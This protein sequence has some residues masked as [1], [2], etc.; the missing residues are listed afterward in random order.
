MACG[1][2]EYLELSRIENPKVQLTAL[3][4]NDK[5]GAQ[6]E[7][8]TRNNSRGRQFIKHPCGNFRCPISGKVRSVCFIQ[9]A[10]YPQ[11]YL[12]FLR[13]AN[14]QQL[15]ALLKGKNHPMTALQIEDVP[16]LGMR[17]FIEFQSRDGLGSKKEEKYYLSPLGEGE[18]RLEWR[19]EADGA[20]IFKVKQLDPEFAQSPAQQVT[21]QIL[22]DNRIYPYYKNN[23]D[24]DIDALRQTM[25]DQRELDRE[26]EETICEEAARRWG[27]QAGKVKPTHSACKA[28][29]APVFDPNSLVTTPASLAEMSQSEN[30]G[31]LEAY[32][33]RMSELGMGD[34]IYIFKKPEPSQVNWNVLDK[35]QPEWQKMCDMLKPR[36][37]DPWPQGAPQIMDIC[38]SCVFKPLHIAANSSFY[39]RLAACRKQLLEFE[40]KKT[41]LEEAEVNVQEQFMEDFDKLIPALDDITKK[42]EALQTECYD[43]YLSTY[44]QLMETGDLNR[45]LK[46]LSDGEKHVKAFISVKSRNRDNATSD[47]ETIEAARQDEKQWMEGNNSRFDKV[48]ADYFARKE[49]ISNQVDLIDRVIHSF[50]QARA[51][52]LVERQ[53]NETQHQENL[54]VQELNQ[55]VV[56][57]EYAK[58]QLFEQPRKQYR[59]YNEAGIA[60][61]EHAAE[62]LRLQCAEATRIVSRQKEAA[63]EEA[64]A[65]RAPLA[66]S[67][68]LTWN[69]VYAN[70]KIVEEG[71]PQ[72]DG[73][74]KGGI[75]DIMRDITNKT[76]DIKRAIKLRAF[77]QAKELTQELKKQ[78]SRL[79]QR[80]TERV[81]FV[82]AR[83]SLRSAWDSKEQWSMERVYN[84]LAREGNIRAAAARS[85]T[86]RKVILKEI[87]IYKRSAEDIAKDNWLEK[88]RSTAKKFIEC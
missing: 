69:K 80:E 10:K 1:K 46:E 33:K 88:K 28:A 58:M 76:A 57:Q 61:C 5:P 73:S 50:Q 18:K 78:K 14:G 3:G 7:K 75:N 45:A 31:V 70:I 60:A 82:Q 4:S 86:E 34:R 6:F 59:K 2:E 74:C 40:D 24:E 19:E 81:K 35:F 23:M 54:K 36:P 16:S 21:L 43:T 85:E 13:R 83:N 64:R 29:R 53:K 62:L 44:K 39:S 41:F 9:S 12:G 11:H 8:R 42:Q 27:S 52:L 72:M 47:A 68:Q 38:E 51:Y 32:K 66:T 48:Y 22:S 63:S 55:T 17:I 25:E 15:L 77:A 67:Y 84:D 79:Q 37:A 65:L 30:F 49:Y 20:E 26:T 87:E 71:V 56:D